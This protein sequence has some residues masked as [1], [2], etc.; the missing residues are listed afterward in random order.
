MEK[1]IGYL[2]LFHRPVFANEHVPY[3]LDHSPHFDHSFSNSDSVHPYSAY[4]GTYSEDITATAEVVPPTA[5]DT[6]RV[7]RRS[8][9]HSTRVRRQKQKSESFRKT[10]ER[11]VQITIHSLPLVI[12]IAHKINLFLNILFY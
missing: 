1:V 9:N 12:H 7:G 2:Y 8:V 6:H 4:A 11:Y 3:S 5:P 10:E